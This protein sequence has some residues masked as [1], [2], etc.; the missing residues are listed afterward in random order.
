VRRYEDIID[1]DGDGIFDGEHYAGEGENT[2]KS[3]LGF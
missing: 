3:R 2:A 1:E